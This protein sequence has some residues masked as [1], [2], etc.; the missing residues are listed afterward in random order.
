VVAF[1]RKIGVVALRRSIGV[2][3]LTRNIGVLLLSEHLL[4]QGSHFAHPA[5]HGG[6]A[7]GI[8]A[9]KT[10]LAFK[11]RRNDSYEAGSK[12]R[13]EPGSDMTSQAGSHVT[14][15]AGSDVTSLDSIPLDPITRDAASTTSA[16]LLSP[17]IQAMP[18]HQCIPCRQV[19]RVRVKHC[20][21]MEWRDMCA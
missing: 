18:C 9:F 20:E 8:E 19:C 11:T 10:G 2:L 1:T 16:H 21:G 14:S 17:C 7:R 4:L 3:A 5:H 15:V 13:Y 6:Q 12:D